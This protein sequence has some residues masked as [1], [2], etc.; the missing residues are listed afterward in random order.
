ML[1]AAALTADGPLPP[2]TGDHGL[3]F[4]TRRGLL[5]LDAGDSRWVVPPGH[6]AWVPPSRLRHAGRHGEFDGW[7][8]TVA[9]SACA[10]LPGAACALRSSGLLN[11]AVLRACTWDEGPLDAVRWRLAGVILDEIRTLRPAEFGLSMPLDPR[12]LSVAG[13]LLGDLAGARSLDDWAAEAAMPARTFTRNFALETGC[14]LADWRQRARLMRALEWLAEDRPVADMATDLGY[15]NVSAFIAMF[16]R[17]TGVT[18][19][20]YADQ[21]LAGNSV[22]IARE[23]P[24]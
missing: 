4:G 14:S 7:C 1:A 23:T 3:L 18:P 8:V 16:R 5:S 24:P 12:L 2:G 20:R 21:P 22:S 15:D 6:V 11:E 10:D 9:E 13:G 19:S 17:A